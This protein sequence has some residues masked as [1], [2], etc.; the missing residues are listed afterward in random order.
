M[1]AYSISKYSKVEKLQLIEV[2]EPN[3]KENEVLVEIHASGL[4]VLDSKIKSGEFKL[5]LPYKFPL[6]LGHD[7]AG[8]ITQIGKNVKQ[9]KVGDEVY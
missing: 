7:V 6:I 1:K 2:A 5:I 8:V 9:F 4:N 3:I